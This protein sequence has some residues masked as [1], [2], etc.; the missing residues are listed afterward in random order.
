MASH[1]S[2]S[3]SRQGNE[4]SSASTTIRS[5]PVVNSSTVRPV[6]HPTAA[7]TNATTR[8]TS[9]GEVK[10]RF[11]TNADVKPPPRKPVGFARPYVESA[12]AAKAAATGGTATIPDV[13]KKSS[14]SSI[15]TKVP[16]C[17]KTLVTNNKG[18]KPTGGRSSTTGSSAAAATAKPK[19][20]RDDDLDVYDPEFEKAHNGLSRIQLQSM[21]SRIEACKAAGIWK[22][23]ECKECK[24]TTDY[25]Y[26]KYSKRGG[27]KYLYCCSTC[28]SQR[29]ELDVSEDDYDFLAN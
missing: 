29:S 10:K 13:D 9:V 25:M 7:S 3:G 8:S 24:Q 23:T 11:G 27:I 21:K 28:W 16:V 15:N 2:L 22:P 5:R 20:G 19:D 14:T 1:K 26:N 4:S 17:K 6:A 18:H 12:P